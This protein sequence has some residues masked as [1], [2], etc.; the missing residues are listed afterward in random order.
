MKYYKW[1]ADNGPISGK[2]RYA[3][4]RTWQP[5]IEDKTVEEERGW[6]ILTAKQIAANVGDTL[7]EVKAKGV[8]IESDENCVCRTWREVRRLRWTQHDM[9]DFV[10]A[11][12]RRATKYDIDE[13]S[14]DTTPAELAASAAEA[15]ARYVANGDP[16]DAKTAAEAATDACNASWN[17]YLYD[18]KYD[19]ATIVFCI[20]SKAAELAWQRSW[21]EK[22]IGETLA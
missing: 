17:Q 19:K 14:V 11:C 21:I 2:G 13:K 6:H 3:K 4:R 15:V 1:L 5:R 10:N 18:S 7:I 12:V 22:R 20:S 9:L 16:K 8:E